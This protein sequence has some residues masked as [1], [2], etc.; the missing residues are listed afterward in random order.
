MSLRALNLVLLSYGFAIGGVLALCSLFE[1]LF[2]YDQA[3]FI[4]APFALA[5]GFSA[6]RIVQ[7]ILG[8]TLEEALKD[9]RES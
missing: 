2:G 7:K 8:Y 4:V 9:G 6:R 3:K 5:L 1:Y